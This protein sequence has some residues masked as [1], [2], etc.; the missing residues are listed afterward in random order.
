MRTTFLCVASCIA[1]ALA[2]S[3]LSWNA[4]AQAEQRVPQLQVDP[5]WPKAAAEQLAARARS[6]ASPSTR[7][8]TSGSCSA[9]RRSASGSSAPRRIRRFGKC[10]VAA[11]PVLVFDQSGNLVRALGRAR[12]RLRVA[13]ERARH[14]RRRDRLR[15]ARRQRRQRLADTQ[16]HARR[17]VPAADRQERAIARQQRHGQPRQPRGHLASTPRRTRC[18]SPTAIATAASSCSI[19]RPG[20]YKRHWGAYGE[21]PSDEPTPAYDPAAPPSR[22]FGNPVHCVRPAR[23]GLVYVCDRVNNR[24]QIFRKDGTFVSEAFFEKNTRSS[25]SVSE[26]AFSPDAEQRFIYMVDG[27][28]NELRIIER[29]TNNVLAS[30]RP[31]RPLCGAIP[32]GSQRRRRLAGQR[33]HDRGEHG[34]ARAA[35]PP[36]RSQD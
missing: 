27:V 36:A 30:R 18:T 19:P 33:L 35:V 31:A 24:V 15:L 20:A 32:R 6:R 12:H 2:C 23:D 16:V 14:L 4:S 28:N 10:C 26:L 8:T 13:R 5:F 17:Q 3:G 34:P 9:P 11:P 29:A 1:A 25:G 21:R 7:A 22:Q